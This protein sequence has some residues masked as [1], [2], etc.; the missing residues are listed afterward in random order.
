M[1]NAPLVTDSRF[2]EHVRIVSDQSYL[3]NKVNL[4]QSIRMLR[5]LRNFSQKHMADE[6]DLSLSGYGKLER[7]E[8]DPSY[9]RLKQIAEILS[10]SVEDLISFKFQYSYGQSRQPAS[11]GTVFETMANQQWNGGLRE[12][13]VDAVD[14]HIGEQ[15]LK[16]KSENALMRQ[17]I[18]QLI[19][20][21]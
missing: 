13:K 6:L 15:I 8:T 19:S 4:G 21:V 18:D 2:D 1:V 12:V 3:S 20:Q 11:S 7:G 10:V 14:H 5:E 17:L 16:L 9:S